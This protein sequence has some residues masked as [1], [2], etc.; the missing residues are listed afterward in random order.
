VRSGACRSFRPATGDGFAIHPYGLLSPPDRPLRHRDDVNLGELG[1]LADT[2]DR[3]QRRGALRAT[4]RRFGIYVDEYGY[5]TNPPDRIGGVS[6]RTQ[7]TWL[8]RA[9]YLAW[10]NPRVKLL[11]QYL[12]RDE[13]RSGDGSYGGW[14]SGLRYVDG[15]PKRSL[16]H[17]DTPFVLDAARR[18]LWG[19]MRPGGA[20]RVTIERRLRGSSTWRSFATATTDARGYFAV[21]RRLTR[22]AAYRFR[23]D[24]ATSAARRR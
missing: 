15:R 13:P 19:Q 5:Q 4:T 1:D 10:R 23:A 8:Q 2:L 14:Q 11:T 22:G 21:R 12:W 9:A 24:G 3:L 17:F 16:A 18:R 6:A 20:H 7:D